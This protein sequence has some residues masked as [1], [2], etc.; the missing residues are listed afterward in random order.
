M[1]ATLRFNNRLEELPRVRE[2][3]TQ[4]PVMQGCATAVIE[5]CWLILDE[6][7]TNTISYGYEAALDRQIE[8]TVGRDGAALSI[9]VR[10]DARA[11]NPLEPP[12]RPGEHPHSGGWGLQLVRS[13]ADAIHYARRDG[14]NVLSSQ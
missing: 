1:S 8:V 6:V 11:F 12:S 4:S 7:L 13:L 14:Y 2:W 5:E 9:E 3:L 10:D